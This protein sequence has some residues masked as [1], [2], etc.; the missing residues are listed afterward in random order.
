MSVDDE[1]L[2]SDDPLKSYVCELRKL[3]ALGREEAAECVRQLRSG[4]NQGEK[5]GRRL[6]EACLLLVVSI[7]ERY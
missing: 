1:T 3:P 5:A 2:V 4:G 6:V 7:A